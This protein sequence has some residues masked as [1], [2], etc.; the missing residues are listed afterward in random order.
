[1]ISFGEKEMIRMVRYINN[2]TQANTTR[3]EWIKPTKMEKEKKAK[4][5]SEAISKQVAN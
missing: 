5:G 2:E 3:Q 1:M 4:F